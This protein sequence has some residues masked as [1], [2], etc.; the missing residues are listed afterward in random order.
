MVNLRRWIRP[1]HPLARAVALGLFV[2]VA[3]A[4]G[5]DDGTGVDDGPDDGAGGDPA[6]KPTSLPSYG[7]LSLYSAGSPL[8][9]PIPA[10]ATLD[11]GSDRY[12]ALL[13][14][15]VQAG[16]MAI[17]LRQYSTP[18]YFADAETPE[19]SVPL[20]CGQ[21]WAGVDSLV[22]VPIPDFAEPAHDVDGASNPIVDGECGEEASQDDQMVVLDPITRCEYDFFQMRREDGRWAASWGNR[23]SMDGP[24]IYEKGLSARG[25]GFTQLAGQIWPDELEAGHISHALIFSY[26]VPAAGGPVPPATESDGFS[27]REW[28]L[29][30]GARLRLDPALDLDGLGLAP[31]ERTI[32]R[33]LQE[34][35][36]FLVDINDTGV[37]LEAI[38]PRSVEGDPYAGLLPDADYPA[39]PNIPADRFQLLE[40]PAQDPLFDERSELVASSCATFR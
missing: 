12:V 29:P 9:Q 13:D 6:V 28:A 4:C 17:E 33:A 35:G 34:Y 11:P 27:D 2:T 23:I 3:G 7:S 14:T 18:V 20:H 37:S 24:G 38:D 15:V 36:M 8:N 19:V 39:L 31:Y 16:G 21:R 1:R 30:E 40:L 10:G 25:S 26:P 22:G 32:A 5:G